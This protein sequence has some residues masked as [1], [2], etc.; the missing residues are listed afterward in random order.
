MSLFLL[1]TVA[2]VAVVSIAAIQAAPVQTVDRPAYCP[3]VKANNESYILQLAVSSVLHGSVTLPVNLTY[4]D[5]STTQRKLLQATAETDYTKCLQALSPITLPQSNLGVCSVQYQCDYDAAR[6]PPYIHHV[7][8]KGEEVN[9]A[10]SGDHRGQ[11]QCHSIYRPL[12]VLRFVGCDPYEQWRMEE[13]VVS[14]G[15]SCVN[16]R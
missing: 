2:L 13:Q 6:F 16:I 11:C 1:S 14:V 5:F 12:T 3:G 8:C 10:K 7:V 9:Y 15:C 4:D